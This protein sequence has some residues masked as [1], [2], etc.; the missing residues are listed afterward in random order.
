[1]YGHNLL[2]KTKHHSQAITMPLLADEIQRLR[3]HAIL[4]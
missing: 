2:G 4:F 3:N 1:M